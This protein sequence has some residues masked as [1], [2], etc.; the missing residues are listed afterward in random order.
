[1]NKPVHYSAFSAWSAQ[2]RAALFSSI[3]RLF[4]RPFSSLLSL[5]VM[6]IALSLPLAFAWSLLQLE[7]LSG[8]V[9]SS[10]AISVFFMPEVTVDQATVLAE[11]YKKNPSV[12]TLRI[13]SPEEGLKEFQ[14]SSELANAVSMLGEN[15]L[16]VVM[17][18]EP[19]GDEGLL[20]TQLNAMPNV[21]QVQHDIA[22]QRRLDAWLDFGKRLMVLLAAIFAIGA[23]LAVANNVRLD[24]ATRVQEIAV[25]QQLG[26]TRG[27]IRRP[28]LYMGGVLGLL[29]CLLAFAL[30]FIAAQ[31]IEPS[32]VDLIS[33]YGSSFRFA[34]FPIWVLPALLF[35]SI[36]LG[37][38]GAWFAVG[39]HIRATRPATL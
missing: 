31:F 10:R 25:L 4:K 13:K 27:Y 6:A 30:I 23:V 39:H 29:A 3:V 1:M 24:I 18:I 19:K 22:W 15:P 12:A 32:I 36:L 37:I 9:Q 8:S 2:H 35:L 28:F 38:L 11:P 14:K 34:Q 5:S 21:E 20:L 33:S 7:Q 26:A 17:I 16:P